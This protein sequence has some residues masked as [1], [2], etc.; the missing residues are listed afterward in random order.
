MSK[1]A[2]PHQTQDGSWITRWRTFGLFLL[3][4][5]LVFF[6][7][8]ARKFDVMNSNTGDMAAIVNSFWNTLH[9]RFFYPATLSDR[10]LH[11]HHSIVVR[12]P[13][14]RLIFCRQPIARSFAL[15]AI[16]SSGSSGR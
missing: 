1:A 3:G 14:S 10:R 11:F 8:A 2:S 4:Y 15:S 16:M 12:K 13:S 7:L 6:A 5:V 9:G